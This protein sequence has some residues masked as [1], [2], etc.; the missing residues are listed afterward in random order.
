M[1]ATVHHAKPQLLSPCPSKADTTAPRSPMYPIME[2]T[3]KKKR[4][5]DSCLSLWVRLWEWKA[6]SL[7]AA[8]QANIWPASGR[9]MKDKDINRGQGATRGQKGPMRGLEGP[10]RGHRGS[11]F[12]LRFRVSREQKV[13]WRK[14]LVLV[15]LWKC[16]LLAHPATKM[17][18]AEIETT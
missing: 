17:Q 18:A 5:N 9:R 14:T 4:E 15:H 11:F 12:P 7:S 3:S 2:R 13:A 6:F 10:Q 16:P 8:L 1:I